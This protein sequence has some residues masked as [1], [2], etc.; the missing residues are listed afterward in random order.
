[1]S[2][3]SPGVSFPL[4]EDNSLWATRTK[5]RPNPRPT[6]CASVR[7]G[8]AAAT[9]P[10]RSTVFVWHST[11]VSPGM[12]SLMSS[13]APCT[14]GSL[15]SQNRERASSTRFCLY[16]IS[17]A[18]ATSICPFCPVFYL[19]LPPSFYSPWPHSQGRFQGTLA[20]PSSRPSS[21]GVLGCHYATP[22]PEDEEEER[23]A[24]K[25]LRPW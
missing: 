19:L 16:R 2:P 17:V 3:N 15:S 9:R 12:F 10:R 7:A 11:A 4:H 8:P 22:Q 25:E 23:V 1:M 14:S 5:L 24:L 6:A 21:V 20:L 18:V 13:L